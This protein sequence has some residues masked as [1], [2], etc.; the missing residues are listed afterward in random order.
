MKFVMTKEHLK[1]DWGDPEDCPFRRCILPRLKKSVRLRVGGSYI[2]LNEVNIVNFTPDMITHF[3]N[4]MY[5]VAKPGFRFGFSIP[6]EFLLK[7]YH[8]ASN[9]NVL[10]ENWS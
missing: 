4:M 2:R 6:N 3:N 5:K 1:G 8:S 7:K 9:D 10:V